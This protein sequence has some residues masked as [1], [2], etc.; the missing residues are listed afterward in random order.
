MQKSQQK[1]TTT[2]ITEQRHCQQRKAL[3][4]SR[5]RRRLEGTLKTSMHLNTDV[6]DHLAHCR[7]AWVAL[8]L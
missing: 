2:L 5:R 8:E 6:G 4:P 3:T 7:I 1:A